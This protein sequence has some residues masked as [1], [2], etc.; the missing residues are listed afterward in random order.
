MIIVS[1]GCGLGNQMFE[2]AYIAKLRKLYPKQEIKIDICNSFPLAHNGYELKEVFGI[3]I[4]ECTEEEF[5]EIVNFKIKGK[6]KFEREIKRGYIAIKQRLKRNSGIFIRQRD[7]TQYYASLLKLKG[8]R[9]YYIKGIFANNKYF[10]DIKEQ[11]LEDFM[12]P[13]IKDAVNLKWAEMIK[14]TESCSIH[15]RRGDYLSEGII[16]LENDYYNLAMGIVE[17]RC[18]KK[19]VFYVFTDDSQ[20]VK[21]MFKNKDNI[22]FIEG[23]KQK[24]SYIDMQLMSLCKHNIIANSSF[25]FWGAY[26]NRN[27]NKIVVSSKQPYNFCKCPFSCEEWIK[28]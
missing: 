4:E 2:Y 8:N 5:K 24:N 21:K 17:E 18:R 28:I 11:L 7:Y 22:F 1:V 25:S 23:N 9:S 16:L 10:T 20:Y 6:N 12:F 14:N 3:D 19:C 15:V 13:A 26:L 27:E